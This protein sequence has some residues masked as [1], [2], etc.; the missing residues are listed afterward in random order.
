MEI[1]EIDPS[2]I[3]MSPEGTAA[4]QTAESDSSRK[5]GRVTENEKYL[6]IRKD[7]LRKVESELRKVHMFR[8]EL[9]GTSINSIFDNDDKKNGNSC[10]MEHVIIDGIVFTIYYLPK[11]LVAPAFGAAG[12]R[13]AVVRNDLPPRV[14]RFVRSH[15]LYHLKDKVNWGG[16][17]GSE[18]RANVIPGLKDPIG[19]IATIWAT[20]TDIDR[21]KYYIQRA[22]EGR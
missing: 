10:Q 17:I 1:K 2:S 20:I 6:N 16:W 19:L 18:I 9:A 4:A 7:E 14:R 12:G 21:V 8:R 3:N 15:E 11:E 22:I 5:K 13:K